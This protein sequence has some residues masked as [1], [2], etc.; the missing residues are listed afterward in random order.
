[1]LQKSRPINLCTATMMIIVVVAALPSCKREERTFHVSP[2]DAKVTQAPSNTPLHVGGTTPT[3]TRIE[4]PSPPP[5]DFESNAYTLARGGYLYKAMNC[6]NCHAAHGGGG[7]GPALSD[8]EWIYGGEPAV[9]F[10]TIVH[11]RPN[12]MPSFGGRISDHQVWQLVSFVRSLS[13]LSST[14]AAPGRDDHMSAATPPNSIGRGTPRSSTR[15]LDDLRRQGQAEFKRLGWI[16]PKSGRVRIPDSIVQA[17]VRRNGTTTRPATA[18]SVGAISIDSVNAPGFGS[19]NDKSLTVSAMAK[20]LSH[21]A[22]TTG[23]ASIPSRGRIAFSNVL[24]TR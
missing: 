9:I 6:A 15:E 20:L 10:D 14:Q 24:V 18:P 12:G 5:D 13:G 21:P 2:A 11:G 1:M 8:E 22:A 23:S 4:F 3:V 19:L 7:I 17:M 16:D